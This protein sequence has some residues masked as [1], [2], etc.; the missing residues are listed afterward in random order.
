MKAGHMDDRDDGH[1]AGSEAGMAAALLASTPDMVL[2]LDGDVVRAVNPATVRL[3]AAPSADGLVGRRLRDLVAEPPAGETGLLGWDRMTFRALDGTLVPVEAMRVPLPG[4][5]EGET[6]VIARD[7]SVQLDV[8]RSMRTARDAADTAN[9]AK[10]RFL[11]GIGHELR[12]P[13]NA[14]IGFAELIV[15]EAGD[16]SVAADYAA[17]IRESGHHLLGVIN[18][19]LDYA[20]IEAGRLDL[21]EGAVDLVQSVASVRRLLAARIAESGL[22]MRVEAADD[23]PPVIG[24]PIKIRQ[25]LLNLVSNAVKFTPRGGTVTVVLAHE[26]DGGVRVEVLDT[27][28]GMTEAEMAVAME[29]FG[30]VA[31]THVRQH[32][33]T[34]LGLPLARALAELHG[35]TFTLDSRPGKGTRAAFR[36]PPSRLALAP[37]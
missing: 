30:Q 36:L 13:L 11:A 6:A 12:T 7:I 34:G 15:D 17:D 21:T 8:E 22:I 1:G 32:D 20:K 9:D 23:L 27:G 4:A 31:N 24:D 33:G 14:I 10:S 5:G 28:I 3:L 29:P 18:G 16:R 37:E 19:I 35:A 25:I 2:R 26:H